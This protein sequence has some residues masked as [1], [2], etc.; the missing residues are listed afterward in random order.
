MKTRLFAPCIV[1][2]LASCAGVHVKETQVASGATHP[3]AIY[4]RPF[5]ISQSVFDGLHVSPGELPIRKSLAPAEFAEDLKEELGK[6]A[7]SLVL[8]ADEAPRRGW[9]VEG[10][11]DVV[12]AGNPV[13]RALPLGPAGRSKVIIHVRISEV[14]GNY[15]DVED[16]DAAGN[17]GKHGNVIYEFDISGGSRWSGHLG[18]VTA[19]GLGYA[20]PFD[21]RNAAER[22]ELAISPDPYGYG[23]RSSSAAR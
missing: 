12:D 4:I 3:L 20:T 5:D 14:G 8:K 15:A 16:K 10:S 21:F 22:I 13:V 11:F 17:Y 19:P 6:I 7:P 18:E 23:I 9:L 2:L 1:V